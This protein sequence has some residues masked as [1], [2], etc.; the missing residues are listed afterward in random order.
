MLGSSDLIRTHCHSQVE[1][2]SLQ[3]ILKLWPWIPGRRGK[4]KCTLWQGIRTWRLTWSYRR[5]S[6]SRV[7]G[8]RG[9]RCDFGRRGRW[10]RDIRPPGTSWNTCTRGVGRSC[11]CRPP[12]SG[13]RDSR[14]QRREHRSWNITE[15]FSEQLCKQPRSRNGLLPAGRGTPSAFWPLED[16]THLRLVGLSWLG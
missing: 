10:D 2:L 12:K 14:G 6:A 13:W 11:R 9:Q 4:W 7:T 3:V 8:S 5:H 15:Q 1:E 16:L